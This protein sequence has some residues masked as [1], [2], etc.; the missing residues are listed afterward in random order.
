MKKGEGSSRNMYKRYMD[1]LKRVG[2]RVGG[3][4]GWVGGDW[5]GENRDNCT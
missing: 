5:L 2:S 3:G 4:D 1:K